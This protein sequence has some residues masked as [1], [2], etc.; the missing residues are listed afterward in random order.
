MHIQFSTYSDPHPALTISLW[1]H[2]S[3]SLGFHFSN[4]VN[5]SPTS[6]AAPDPP[7][8][9]SSPHSSSSIH[10]SLQP[11]YS[12]SLSASHST[13]VP[14]LLAVH[15]SPVPI[16]SLLNFTPACFFAAES[17]HFQVPSLSAH[18]LKAV[19]TYSQRWVLK[20]PMLRPKPVQNSKSIRDPSRV[21]FKLFRVPP[22][23]S[24]FVL[25]GF[26]TRC[27]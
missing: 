5:H 12:S 7:I 10:S 8:P 22:S 25:C 1:S 14:S 17:V 4:T 26:L 3:P 16:F 15:H 27:F 24:G 2:Y 18:K 13:S 9:V 23:T 11:L 21:S 6:T 19:A 20:A